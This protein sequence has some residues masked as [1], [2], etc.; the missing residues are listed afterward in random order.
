MQDNPWELLNYSGKSNIHLSRYSQETCRTEEFGVFL[1]RSCPNDILQISNGK[2]PANVLELM[3]KYMG[4]SLYN[5]V[6][7]QTTSAFLKFCQTNC[8]GNIWALQQV[9]ILLPP[10]TCRRKMRSE[11][12]L[13]PYF[14]TF[15]IICPDKLWLPW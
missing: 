7:C 15:K 11:F 2:F 5:P 12:R 6:K 13:W 10:K 1:L 3:Q 4:S 14:I 8:R 9:Y